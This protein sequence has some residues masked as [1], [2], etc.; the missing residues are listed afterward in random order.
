MPLATE[1]TCLVKRRHS[2]ASTQLRQ[3]IL[4]A[5]FGRGQQRRRAKCYFGPGRERVGPRPDDQD[6]PYIDDLWN[7][8]FEEHKPNDIDD[9]VSHTGLFATFA[10]IQST[11]SFKTGTLRR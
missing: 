5:I 1:T 9:L 8:R 7:V 10:S 2:E 6:E 3:T 11:S 4:Q